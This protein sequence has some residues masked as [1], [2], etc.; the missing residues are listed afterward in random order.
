[1][2]IICTLG[3]LLVFYRIHCQKLLYRNIFGLILWISEVHQWSSYHMIQQ[4]P[5]LLIVIL[6]GQRILTSTCND[7]SHQANRNIILLTKQSSGR[8]F[9]SQPIHH[10]REWGVQVRQTHLMRQWSE[11]ITW[12][13]YHRP[14]AA[15]V[16]P[17]R[18]H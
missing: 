17:Q 9:S 11:Q 18:T 4:S 5:F 14:T 13:L 3:Q 16:L 7:F 6:I 15:I 12:V 2:L 1:M 8:L 10:G